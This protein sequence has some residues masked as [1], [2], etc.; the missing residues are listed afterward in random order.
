MSTKGAALAA[1]EVKMAACCPPTLA[2]SVV[3]VVDSASLAGRRPMV[4]I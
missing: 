2:S 3:S 4:A 1:L